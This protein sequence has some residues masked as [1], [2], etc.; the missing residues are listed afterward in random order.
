MPSRVNCRQ[1][2]SEQ[3]AGVLEAG[4]WL[5]LAFQGAD[6]VLDV[7]STSEELGK[8]AGKDDRAGKATWVR[9]EG[10][11]RAAKRARRHGE[12]GL[13]L[14]RDQLPADADTGPLLALCRYMWQREH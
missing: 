7:T 2:A 11:A 13:A 6:D 9:I 12:R 5:G 8:T 14:L 1:A 3:V 10:V 4:H